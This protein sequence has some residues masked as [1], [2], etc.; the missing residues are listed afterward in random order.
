MRQKQIY[1]A[2]IVDEVG[3]LFERATPYSL[4]FS[5]VMTLE[6]KV[7]SDVIHQALDASLKCHPKMKCVLVE[8]YPSRKRWFTHA[9]EYR[10]VRSRDILEEIELSQADYNHTDVISNIGQ[11]HHTH[12]I[13]I[14]S[15]PPLKVLLIRAGG[16]VHLIFFVHHAAVDGLAVIFFVQTFIKYYES[17]FYQR[18][19][20][21]PCTPD[22]ESISRPQI[23]FRWKNFSPK[24]VRTYIKNTSLAKREPPVPLYP[25]D[26]EQGEKKLIAAVRSLSPDQFQLLRS[27][28]RKEQTTINNYLL[29]S[30]FRT[31]R[32]WNGRWS[33][34]AGRIY[35]SVPINLRPPGDRSVGN[36]ISGY[37]F[38]LETEAISDRKT[39]LGFMQK[40][41]PPIVKHA[42]NNTNLLCFLKPLPLGVKIKMFERQAPQVGPTLLLSNWGTCHINPDHTDSE[43]F[44]CMGEASIKKINTIAHPVQWPQL[45]VITY[46]NVLSVSFTVLRSH[47]PV[48]TADE[49]LKCF[50]QDLMA[51]T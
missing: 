9:W 25:R 21:N 34:T 27:R 31:I 4:T 2:S 18:K 39:L 12:S 15:E 47:F 23:R 8:Q 5:F 43:G 10:E 17:I 30:M 41:W 45:T 44:N 19:Q 20:D 46:N 42:R 3:Y 40:E 36:I 49:F 14:T 33:V 37:Y 22:F 32:S 24:L 51:E 16:S 28:A 26:E 13:D 11:Y 7:D 1:P 48:E 38:S 35:V 6:G 50:I 29:S